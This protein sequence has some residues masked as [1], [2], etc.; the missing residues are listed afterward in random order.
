MSGCHLSSGF[1]GKDCVA[2]FGFERTQLSVF[3]SV[4]TCGTREFR[5]SPLFPVPPLRVRWLFLW[6]RPRR[7]FYLR[8]ALLD[9]CRVVH[10][11]ANDSFRVPLRILYARVP[12]PQ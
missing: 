4:L 6:S 11:L 1:S 2:E 3:S 12:S 10:V 8:R 5:P 9:L 7:P